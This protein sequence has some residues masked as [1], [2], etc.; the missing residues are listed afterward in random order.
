MEAITRK[1]PLHNSVVYFDFFE[2]FLEPADFEDEFLE[3]SQ[4]NKSTSASKPSK[5]L[6]G[7]S[8]FFFIL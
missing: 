2:D 5:I 7:I 6:K 8:L 1:L 3:K 4:V